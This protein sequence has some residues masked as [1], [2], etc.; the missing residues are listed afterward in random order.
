MRKWAVV[1]V[2]A[3]AAGEAARSADIRQDAVLEHIRF[4]AADDMKGRANG[5]AELDRAA[6]YIAQQF[7]DIGLEPGGEDGYFQPFE[8]Q[9]GLTIGRTNALSIRT[10]GREVPFALGA[11]Y[12]PL[13][14]APNDNAASPS[15]ALDDVPLVFA[16]YGLSIP[17]IGYDDYADLDVKDKAGKTLRDALIAA[18]P[19]VLQAEIQL[20]EVN[21]ILQNARYQRDANWRQLAYLMG[22]PG[23]TPST[24]VGELEETDGP[25]DLET[26]RQQLLAL[27][28]QLQQARAEMAAKR[29]LDALAL[30]LP[31]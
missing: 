28:P 20:Q 7:K 13:G 3:I 15:T 11:S 14:T 22:T 16:G 1:A 12:Y 27:S 24:L 29:A 4:L 23:M 18:L 5:T 19:D 25:R 21:V 31:Q 17:T 9:V 2:L 30:A 8:L 10:D 6:D 26:A